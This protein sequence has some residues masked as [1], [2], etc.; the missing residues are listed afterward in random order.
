MAMPYGQVLGCFFVEIL[1]YEKKII[2]IKIVL[3]FQSSE[4]TVPLTKRKML[5]NVKHKTSLWREYSQQFR[6]RIFWVLLPNSNY[7]GLG[8]KAFFKIKEIHSPIHITNK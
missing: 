2:S 7:V 8:P 1:H 6:D 4:I 3:F 5:E